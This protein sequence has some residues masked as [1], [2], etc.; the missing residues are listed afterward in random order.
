MTPSFWLEQFA[1]LVMCALPDLFCTYIM[2][3]CH[4]RGFSTSDRSQDATR[5]RIGR[6]IFGIRKKKKK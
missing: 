1:F 4:W 5:S 6:G 3:G 2:H